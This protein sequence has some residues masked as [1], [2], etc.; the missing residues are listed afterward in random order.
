MVMETPGTPIYAVTLK[1]SAQTAARFSQQLA[2]RR[3]GPQILSPARP[4]ARACPPR[5]SLGFCVSPGLQQRS[6]K[7]AVFGV[8][9]QVQKNA[10]TPKP[11]RKKGNTHQEIQTIR[12]P[13]SRDPPRRLVSLWFQ[14]KYHWWFGGLGV[15]V[16]GF[17][18]LV[19]WGS[20][21]LVVW[22]FVDSW[23]GGVVVWWFGGLWIGGLVEWWSGGLVVCG[24][25][26][27][28]SGGVV[29][30]W[31]V[32]WW[33]GGVVVWWFGGLVVCGLVVWWS[34][35]LVVWWFVDWW[36]GGVVEWWFGGLWIGGLEIGHGGQ[37]S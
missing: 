32:D 22:W 36:F 1:R 2:A 25:V 28:W 19:V 24:L 26:V 9:V 6:T 12:F 20:G 21:G 23:L 34:G 35:G 33:F 8:Q 10:S 3:V 27:W 37:T 4:P 16:W 11:V 15:L 30:W 29:V 18:G 5:F 13:Q 17:R 7:R 31:F 14:V